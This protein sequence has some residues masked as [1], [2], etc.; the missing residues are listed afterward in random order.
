M[1]ARSN[2][3]DL[4]ADEQYEILVEE[5]DEAAC[6]RLV[7]REAFG[8][9]GFVHGGEVMVL[10]VNAVVMANRVVFRTADDTMSAETRSPSTST[11]G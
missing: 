10:P 9:I 1:H 2:R 4:M 3:R 8:R 7:S 6:R 5:L 11:C